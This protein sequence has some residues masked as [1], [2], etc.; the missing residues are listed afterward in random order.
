MNRSEVLRAIRE[1][2]EIEHKRTPFVPGE[3]VVG[4]AGRVFDACDME[5]LVDAALD[6]WLTMGRYNRRFEREFKAFLGARYAIP[7]NSGSSSNL[8]ALSALT[9]QR[10]GKRRLAPGDEVITV[11]AGFPTTVNPIIQNGLVPVFVDIDLGTYNANTGR[12][13]EALSGKTK[14]I[15]L[16]HTLGNPFDLETITDVARSHNLWLIEDN[17][18]SLGTKYAGRYTGTFGDLA[19]HSF[20]PAHHITTGE[21]GCVVTDTPLLKWLIESFREWGRDCWCDPGQTDTCGKR[22][23][24]E[25]GRL[26]CGYDHKYTYSHI[27]YGLKWTDMQAALGC[28]QLKKLPRFIEARRYNWQR[29]HDGLSRYD[30]FLQLP[31]ATP[32][33]EPAWF[34][35]P[36]FVR[37]D[38]PF[39]RLDL[40][41]FLEE[42]RVETRLLFGGNL[43]RQPAYQDVKYRIVGD[44][45][46]SDKAMVGAFWIGVYPG[47][48]DAH[49]DYVLEILEEFMGQ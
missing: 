49:L 6:F 8:L 39:S 23:E 34:G 35:F 10:L 37:E 1:F 22:F 26:P 30:E 45:I 31:H 11:A 20:Y 21:G 14:A 41:K 36:I 40:I 19:T 12:V 27:G 44:L 17:C 29:L 2:S 16:A 38:A 47:L 25:L 42:K 4:V 3:S 15:M 13:G 33:S 48:T 32:N 46:N 18:D 24:H 9:S 5:Y 43:T 7:C 28:S